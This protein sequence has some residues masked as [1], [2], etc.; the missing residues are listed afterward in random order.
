MPV[1]DINRLPTGER[2]PGWKDHTF[3]SERMTFA[4]FDFTAGAAIHEHCHSNEEVWTVIEGKLEVSIGG[5]S[6]VAG[7]G[8]VAIVPPNTAHSVLALTDGKAI[9]TDSPIRADTSGG[10]RGVI[11]IEFSQP[12]ALGA[13]GIR[14]T[15]SNIG[16]G[17]AV[18]KRV[19]LESAAASALP[20][21]A[22]TEVPEGELPTRC[23]IG[24]GESRIEEVDVKIDAHQRA[25][26][27]SGAAVLY[28]RGT[29][30][31][32]DDFGSRWHRT[33]CAVFDPAAF[34]GAGGF[35]AP[36]KPGYNYGS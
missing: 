13:R 11:R 7:P 36:A 6:M 16:K 14:C 25:R 8:C 22:T 30:V 10:K 2:L 4:H 31:Y 32:D 28:V 33:F 15:L 27:A 23:A 12:F 18:V 5:D 19:E 26:I 35:I 34:N 29:I 1:I 24:A 20:P 17:R 9:V 21:P 3:H